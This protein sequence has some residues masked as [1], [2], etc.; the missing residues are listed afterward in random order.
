M[1]MVKNDINDPLLKAL[2]ARVRY[3]AILLRKGETQ[4]ALSVLEQ[5]ERC[6][7]LPTKQNWKAAKDASMRGIK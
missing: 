1:T 2:S 6:L 4:Q 5:C 7:P 3:S